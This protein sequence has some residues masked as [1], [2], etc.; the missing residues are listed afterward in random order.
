MSDRLIIGVPVR[1]GYL[2]L[3]SEERTV[4]L[5][6]VWNTGLRTETWQIKPGSVPPQLIVERDLPDPRDQYRTQSE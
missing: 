5:K 4:W 1:E 3:D 2:Q 6:H